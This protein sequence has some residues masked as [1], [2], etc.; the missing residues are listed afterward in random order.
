MSPT[1]DLLREITNPFRRGFAFIAHVPAALGQ[2]EPG[3]SPSRSVTPPSPFAPI[4]PSPLSIR[5]GHRAILASD[6]QEKGE[7]RSGANRSLSL[8][9]ERE[10][11]PPASPGRD[12]A[13]NPAAPQP[14]CPVLLCHLGTP[15]TREH[16]QPWFQP[17]WAVEL[18]IITGWRCPSATCSL[19]DTSCLHEAAPGPFHLREVS[20]RHDFPRSLFAPPPLPV[21]YGC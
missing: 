16:L 11:V 8:L 9:E 4:C 7:S 15:G 13:A 6:R 17:P 10:A 2:P 18:P 21:P 20:S 1:P 12:K 3:S 19:A 14:L 5:P